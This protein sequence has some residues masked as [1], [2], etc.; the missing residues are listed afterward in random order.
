M[1]RLDPQLDEEVVELVAERAHGEP[2]AGRQREPE[3]EPVLPMDLHAS[4]DRHGVPEGPGRVRI[5]ERPGVVALGRVRELLGR[6]HRR[7]GSRGC[8]DGRPTP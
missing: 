2:D 4:D 5:G 3:L 1:V 8:G 6:E 7:E